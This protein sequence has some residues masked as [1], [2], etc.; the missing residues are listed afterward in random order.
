MSRL[1][2]SPLGLRL[3]ECIHAWDGRKMVYGNTWNR[4]LSRISREW[5]C[6]L[7]KMSGNDHKSCS[8]F[9]IY[10][11][12]A[13][14]NSF[15][16][17]YRS[18]CWWGRNAIIFQFSMLLFSLSFSLPLKKRK[19]GYETTYRESNADGKQEIF[20]Q[21]VCESRKFSGPKEH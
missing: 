19:M 7:E 6:N 15:L 13:A 11:I 12:V 1:P 8:K 18:S 2:V 9:E 20:L 14:P 3:P 16:R 4:S 21:T 10:A 17:L 5:C